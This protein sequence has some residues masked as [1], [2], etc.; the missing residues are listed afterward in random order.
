MVGMKKKIVKKPR[1]RG[2][3][4]LEERVLGGDYCTI[5]LRDFFPSLPFC[6]EGAKR[7]RKGLQSQGCFLSIRF[8]I[9]Q[10]F[11]IDMV[12]PLLGKKRRSMALQWRSNGAPLVRAFGRVRICNL[13]KVIFFAF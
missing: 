6:A 11:K 1:T 5:I 13:R 10:V 3:R 2:D 12:A 9:N 8:F 7:Q 4:V